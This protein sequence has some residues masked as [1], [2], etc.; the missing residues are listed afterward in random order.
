LIGMT[1]HDI[2]IRNACGRL[3]ANV[4][5]A[6]NSMLLS[7]LL[8]RYQRDGNQKALAMLKEICPAART[9]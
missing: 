1:G 5:I 6:F 7:A 8:E 2:A 9:A 3:L 4:V